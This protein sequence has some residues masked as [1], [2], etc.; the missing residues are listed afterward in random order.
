MQSWSVHSECVMRG[1]SEH[2]LAAVAMNEAIA[3]YWS[4]DRRLYLAAR[5]VGITEA[6]PEV[7]APA[8]FATEHCT[9]H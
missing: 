8:S 5:E 6:Q 2:W 9:E 1:D 3:A 4:S 7:Q